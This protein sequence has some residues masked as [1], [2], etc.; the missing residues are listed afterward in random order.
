MLL[1][2]SLQYANL[3]HAAAAHPFLW[4]SPQPF[5]FRTITAQIHDTDNDSAAVLPFN[6]R[7]LQGYRNCRKTVSWRKNNSIL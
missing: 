3:Q 5:H 2:Y 6:L 1:Q 4:K 7:E